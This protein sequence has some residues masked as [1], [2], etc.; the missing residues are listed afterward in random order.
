M[1]EKPDST[2]CQF[3]GYHQFRADDDDDRLYGCFRV[4]FHEKTLQDPQPTG[5]YWQS[6]FPGYLPDSDPF[7]PFPT[8]QR[9]Y[10]DAWGVD[11]E[12]QQ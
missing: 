6:G 5:W 1:T 10:Q 4:F 12:C 7:G 3:E 8:S 2:A 11:L 9:A